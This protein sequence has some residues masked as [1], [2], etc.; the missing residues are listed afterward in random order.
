MYIPEEDFESALS[1]IWRVL[2]PGGELLVWEPIFTIAPEEQ[3]K[4]LAVIPLEIHLPNGPVIETGYGGILR[5][6]DIET[7]IR[8]AK[9]TGFRV[10]E[11]K[12]DKHT[13]FVKFQKPD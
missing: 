12:V 3:S 13:F 5:D 10:I 8:P 1:E 9:K 11:K 4:K 7:I 6:Q 2:K